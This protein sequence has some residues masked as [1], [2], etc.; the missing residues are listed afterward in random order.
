MSRWTAWF[1]A[2]HSASE[3]VKK[4][5]VEILDSTKLSLSLAGAAKICDRTKLSEHATPGLWLASKLMFSC[6]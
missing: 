4:L 3:A 5:I 2:E 6:F 1:Y